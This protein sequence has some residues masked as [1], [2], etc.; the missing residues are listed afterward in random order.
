VRFLYAVP[1][2]LVVV[3]YLIWRHFAAQVYVGDL[4]P[5]DLGPYDYAD[6]L[7]YVE[8]LNAQ[9]KAV[10]LG[11]LQ[12]AD[13]GLMLALTVTLIL[14]L[15]RW[16]WA[17]PAALYLGF[18]LLENWQVSLLLTRGL[19]EMGQVATLSLYT[20]AKFGFLALAVVAAIWGVWRRWRA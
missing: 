14:P 7:T 6:A 15:R 19:T 5:F 20:G 4:P 3:G 9:A 12:R 13:L 2:G 17:I 16:I 1:P 11:P 10:Y 8:G 18:D